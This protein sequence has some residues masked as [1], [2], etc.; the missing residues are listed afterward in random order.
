MGQQVA[1]AFQKL[2]VGGR[3]GDGAGM[4]AMPGVEFGLQAIAFGQ[5]GAVL[6][7]QVMHQ[8]SEPLPER[9][10]GQPGAG[11]RL[12]FD[13]LAEIGRHLQAVVL[14]ALSHADL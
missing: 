7:R 8:G 9:V 3:I 1:D 4:G 11:Q 12:L 10:S 14:D 5:Q 6:G 2:A 13:E